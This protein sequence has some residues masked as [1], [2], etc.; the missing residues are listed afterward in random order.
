[1]VKFEHED[2]EYRL[3]FSHPTHFV[4]T[5]KD[6]GVKFSS[7]IPVNATRRC[8]EC[9]VRMSNS[10]EIMGKSTAICCDGDNF[11][12]D[13]GRKESLKSVLRSSKNKQ[14]RTAAWKAYSRQH[15]VSWS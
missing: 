13:T 3:Y 7:H 5:L 6:R 1:M 11:C 9:V 4:Q 15:A 8:T 10:G 12:K 2:H 14:F